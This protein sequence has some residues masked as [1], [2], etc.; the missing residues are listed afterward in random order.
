MADFI[1]CKKIQ[2][3][4]I[5]Y[6][7][8][9]LPLFMINSP[10]GP[11]PPIRSVQSNRVVTAKHGTVGTELMSVAMTLSVASDYQHSC[12]LTI[13][14]TVAFSSLLEHHPQFGMYENKVGTAK[15]RTDRFGKCLAY[16]S[17]RDTDESFNLP[18]RLLTVHPTTASSP[19]L[20][21]NHQFSM[22]KITE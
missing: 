17:R 20:G 15:H 21:H 22:Y 19:R 16:V 8:F 9:Y 11:P 5:C 3:Q 6:I 1:L 18:I 14:T 13:Q 10:L 12:L 2:S 7:C 4:F